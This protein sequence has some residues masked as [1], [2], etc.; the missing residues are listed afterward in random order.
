[1][2]SYKESL[3]KRNIYNSLVCGKNHTPRPHNF[4]RQREVASS[5]RKEY[6][7]ELISKK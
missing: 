5:G 2:V 1:M 7:K 6:N 4:N 3:I